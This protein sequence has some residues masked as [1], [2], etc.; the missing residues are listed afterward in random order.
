MW[1]CMRYSLRQ[2]NAE[3]ILDFLEVFDY[4]IVNTCFRKLESILSRAKVRFLALYL[5]GRRVVKYMW[6]NM[7]KMVKKVAKETRSES[8]CFGT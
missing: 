6:D 4:T 7:A 8:R 5:G 1:V 3:D 2:D